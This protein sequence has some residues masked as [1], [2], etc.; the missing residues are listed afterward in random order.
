MKILA[1][2]PGSKQSGYRKCNH[3]KNSVNGKAHRVAAELALGKK[4]PKGAEVHHFNGGIDGPIVICQDRA[5]HRLIEIRT[6]AKAVTGDF[7]KRKCKFCKKWDIQEN[8]V[9][10]RKQINSFSHRVCVRKYER[11]GYHRRKNQ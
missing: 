8:M 4:I 5:Y 6:L 2:D 10:D 9:P 1:I 3:Y 7:N 11:E